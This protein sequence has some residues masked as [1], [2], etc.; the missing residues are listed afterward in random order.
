MTTEE[1][2]AVF[3][4]IP[5]RLFNRGDLTIIDEVFSDDYVEHANIGPD[6]PPT[7]DAVRQFVPMLRAAFPDL[8][9]EVEDVVAEGDKVVGRMTVT[10]THQGDFATP[11][12]AIPATGRQ[13]RWSEIHIG[14][15]ANG[16]LV[17][18]WVQQDVMGLMQQLGAIPSP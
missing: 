8:H 4:S 12:G 10:G 17:E 18:H 6:I 13:V 7:R 9:Y 14:R 11:G 15:F 5:E 1:Y 3:S 16:K 2:K